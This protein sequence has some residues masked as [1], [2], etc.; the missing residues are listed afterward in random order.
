VPP[1]EAPP[2]PGAQDVELPPGAPAVELPGV[3]LPPEL[4]GDELPSDVPP[5]PVA[6]EA[7]ADIVEAPPEADVPDVPPPADAD[8]APTEDPEPL[9]ALAVVQPVVSR[10][11]PPAVLAPPAPAP[12][13]ATEHDAVVEPGADA[14]ASIDAGVA[15]ASNADPPAPS[16]G[17]ATPEQEAAADPP[18]ATAD[19]AQPAAVP[20]ADLAAHLQLLDDRLFAALAAQQSPLFERVQSRVQAEP[21][22]ID[23]T[24][25]AQVFTADAGSGSEPEIAGVQ[26]VAIAERASI[27]V[28]IVSVIQQVLPSTGGPAPATLGGALLVLA[29]LGVW[30]RRLG[31]ER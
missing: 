6:E 15:E 10:R 26:V 24:Y 28:Q 14:S 20:E 27:R 16:E 23:E 29:S 7:V 2:P 5:P 8:V 1:L 22:P 11:Q 30:L 4:P 25:A 19:A 21:P 9:E 13:D 12:P 17:S 31:R 3:E 18:A